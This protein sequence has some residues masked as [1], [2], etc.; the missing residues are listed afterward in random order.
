[1]IFKV[2]FPQPRASGVLEMRRPQHPDSRGAYYGRGK[3]AQT[4]HHR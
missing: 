4:A 3:V 2:S 1:M